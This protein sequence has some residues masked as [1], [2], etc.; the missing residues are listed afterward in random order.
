MTEVLNSYAIVILEFLGE[1]LIFCAL[2]LRKMERAERFPL[3]LALSLV[4]LLLFALPVAWFYTAFGGQIWGRI[5]VYLALFWAVVLGAYVCM[6]ESFYAVL[7]CCSMAYAAQNL[8]YKVFLVFWTGGEALGLFDSWGRLFALWYRLVYYSFFAAS[9]AV[10]YF[11]FIRRITERLLSRRLN[12]RMLVLTV[13]VLAVT[14]VLCSLD[15]ICFALLSVGRENK[16][17]DPVYTVLRETGNAFSIVCCGIVL[18]LASK[19]IVERE[20][21]EEVEYLKYA[22]RQSELQYRMSKDTIELINIKCHDIKYKLSALA[23]TGMTPEAVDELKQS[24]SIYDSHIE[25]G[26]GLLDVLLTEKSL[27]CEQNGITLSCMIDGDKLAFMEAGDLYCL[28]GNLID[29]ALEAVRKLAERERRVVNLTVK[30]RDGLLLVQEENYFDGEL[31]FEDGLPV[32]TKE[33]SGSHGFGTRSLRMIA[34][35]YGGEMAVS[36]TG[37]I[38]R[39]N[40]IFSR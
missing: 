35:K 12:R 22:V 17:S 7:F 27:F 11:L 9:A 13:C 28:F 1:M 23:A 33:D 38:F 10:T 15:D 18:L 40:I 8:V 3:R 14:I 20:L 31:G 26:N 39:L 37:D 32:T 16:F 34:R 29:N 4:A 6:H 36:A 25:T 5:L 21:L 19:T 24:I 2:F 30:A